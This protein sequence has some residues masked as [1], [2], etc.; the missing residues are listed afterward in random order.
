MA[1]LRLG[2]IGC[3][4]VSRRH[5]E[6]LE[7]LKDFIDVVAVCDPSAEKAGI[8]AEKF[9][10]KVY[11]DI[12]KML[13][14]EKLDFCTIATPNGMHGEHAITCARNGVSVLCEKP[15]T[16]FLE[17]GKKIV[18]TFKSLKRDFFLIHQNRYNSTVQF[19]KNAIDT[20]KFGKLYML[21]SNVFWQRPEEYFVTEK[22]HGTKRLDG[23]S[24]MTQASH[25]VDT[26]NWFA[27]GDVRNIYAELDTLARH[28]ETEDTGSVIIKW[29]NGIIGNVNVT[30]LTYP[31]NYEG[32]ITI[33]GE[34]GTVKIGGVALNKIEHMEFEDYKPSDE[35]M[36]LVNYDTPSVYGFG[37]EAVY[38]RLAEY[39]KTGS[40]SDL[41]GLEEAFY[42]LRILDAIL[43]SNQAKQPI[44]F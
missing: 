5:F 11:T 31:R 4:R 36:A 42:D 13:T 29:K 28:I 32:S 7:N 27:G 23:G 35:E 20:G 30:I 2:F 37:H 16:V 43:T 21:T 40:K 14:S 3:G 15:M 6:A 19:V 9:G 33:I 25:Y 12:E 22:W 17:D 24:F 18:D 34:K 44:Y 38:K 1:K 41:I 39:V 10:A 8:P 26:I